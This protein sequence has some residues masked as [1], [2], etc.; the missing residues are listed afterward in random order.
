[1]FCGSS[2]SRSVAV[3]NV[4]LITSTRP[5][6]RPPPRDDGR[7]TLWSRREF[8]GPSHAARAVV[9]PGMPVAHQTHMAV[10]GSDTCVLVVVLDHLYLPSSLVPAL[11]AEQLVRVIGERATAVTDPARP[12]DLG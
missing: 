4:E 5:V 7:V 2:I 6:T 11:M 12:L 9:E 8:L 3:A 1:M 10:I